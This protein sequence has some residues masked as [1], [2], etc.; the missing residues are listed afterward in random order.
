[1]DVLQRVRRAPERLLHPLR[2]RKVLEGLRGR[3]KPSRVVVVCYGNI[4]RSPVAALLL[5]RELAKHGIEVQSAGLVGFNRPSPDDAVAV[6]QDHHVDLSTHRSRLLTADVVRAADVLLVMD[7]VQQRQICERFGRLPGDVMLLGDFDPEAVDGRTIL[8]PL[9]QGRD[10]F[11]RVY[12]RIARCVREFGR[13]FGG[14]DLA[15]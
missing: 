15:P 7:S 4:C 11:Q 2:R 12:S 10:V 6:A 1:M 8:D 9:D 5:G 3:R 13:A 14:R